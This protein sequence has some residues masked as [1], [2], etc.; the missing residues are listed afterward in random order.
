MTV[1]LLFEEQ[2]RAMFPGRLPLALP[3]GGGR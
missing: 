2:F 1:A 3:Q